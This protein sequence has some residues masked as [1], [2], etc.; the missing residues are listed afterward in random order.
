MICVDTTFLIDLWRNKSDAD[1]PTVQVLERYKGET[2]MIPAH[3]AGEFMEGGACISEE[4]FR[5]SLRF[6][7]MFHLAAVGIETA[8]QYARIVSHM[9]K[10]SKLVG[11]SKPDLW[12]AACSIEHGAILVTR[13]ARHFENVPNL[14]IE[15]Y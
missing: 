1:H 8:I 11:S 13:N 15:S 2:F 5:D 14:P 4:R 7:R 6:V 12:I 10:Q 3:A 9:R